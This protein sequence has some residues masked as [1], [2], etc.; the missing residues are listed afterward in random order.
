MTIRTGVR[1]AFTLCLA[2]PLTAAAQDAPPAT[3]TEAAPQDVRSDLPAADKLIEQAIVAMGGE[4]AMKA[5]TNSKVLATMVTPMGNIAM[6]M[7]AGP[8]GRFL[9]KQNLPGMG[10]MASG[11]DGTV[12]WMHNPMT[13]GYQIVPGDEAAAMGEQAR[14]HDMLMRAKKQYPKRET[15]ERKSFKDK[16]CFVVKMTDAKGQ[17]QISYFDAKSSL[18]VAIEQEQMTQRGAMKATT[19]FQ[20]WKPVGGLK[21]FHELAIEQMGMELKVTFNEISFDDIDKAVFALPKEVSE[22]TAGAGGEA[23]G[24]AVEEAAGGAGGE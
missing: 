5:I 9:L 17:E 10:E 13:G 12:T 1:I 18:P 16:D 19:L 20:N 4:E 15:I 2:L 23:A 6:E 22:L 3:G 8:E 7:Y 21:M 14:P 24:G 11:S